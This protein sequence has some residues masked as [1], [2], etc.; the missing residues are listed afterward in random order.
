MKIDL[1]DL[2]RRT[3]YRRKQ[4]VALPIKPTEAQR[5]ELLRIYMRLV[6]G[7]QERARDRILPVYSRSLSALITDDAD[8]L[9]FEIGLAESQ[10]AMLATAA[11]LS[12]SEWVAVTERW[13]RKRFATTFT[14]AGVHIDTLLDRG[15]VA[16]TLRSAI[17]ENVA[18]IRSIDD[19]M[20]NGISG[21]VFRG[22]QARTPA[23][24][25]AR[26]IRK[27]AGVSQRRAELIASDQLQKLTGELDQQRQK[28]VGL[29]KFEWAHSGK[30][31]FREEHKARDGKV[32]SWSGP[33][34]KNDP[35]GRAIRCGCRARAV[36]EL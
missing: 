22:L 28:Q 29:S 30:V 2:V 18:L 31:N 21:A 13:H 14:P 1:V 19:Q 25:V 27:I 33:V 32:Y 11:G 20:R 9:Q 26:E 23:R 10:I 12:V 17:A 15:D 4:F 16:V 6:R 8:A 24:D 3:G 5:I 36:L 35:P 7:W 34:A